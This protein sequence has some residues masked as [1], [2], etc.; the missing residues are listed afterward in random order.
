MPEARVDLDV[1]G[2]AKRVDRPVASGD[3]VDPR[4]VGPKRELVAPVDAFLVPP[5]VIRDVQPSADVCDI[6]VGEVADELAER[7]RAP[8][9]I[10]VRE[11]ND[12]GVGLAHR[13]VL[14]RDLAAA[15][16]ADHPRACGLR[17]RLGP[18]RGCVRRHD[19]LEALPG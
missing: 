7:V 18:V 12:L 11:R 9:A 8:G 4:L 1:V 13:A 17:E 5:V 19:D 3:G 10:R 6:G 2:A 14:R 15:G 16:V